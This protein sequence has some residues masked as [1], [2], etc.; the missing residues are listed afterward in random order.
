MLVM[1]LANGSRLVFDRRSCFAIRQF[2]HKA[3]SWVV[4]N[5][6]ALAIGMRITQRSN[7]HPHMSFRVAL[8][9]NGVA[10]VPPAVD[11]DEPRRQQKRDPGAESAEVIAALKTGA[12]AT[13]L[14]KEIPVDLGN[15]VKMEFVLIPA[16]SFLMG[17]DKGLKDERPV[18]RVVI[19]RPFYLAK[20]E[21]TQ[22]QW[23]TVMGKDARLTEYAMADNERPR[24]RTCATTT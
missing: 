21:V 15:G 1:K 2:V 9:L 14:D 11:L 23:E 13:L 12:S 4:A 18:H 17:S 20:Y 3:G 24:H 16:G 7:Q 22:S 10:G 8:R 6:L 19:S 5:A